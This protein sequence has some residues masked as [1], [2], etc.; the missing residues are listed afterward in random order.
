MVWGV[1]EA[2]A[3]APDFLAVACA[4]GLRALTLAS[5][6]SPCWSSRNRAKNGVE[7]A[8]SEGGVAG[9]FFFLPFICLSFREAVESVRERTAASSITNVTSGQHFFATRRDRR[10]G[11]RLEG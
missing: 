6:S 4:R 9:P 11:G 2:F 7:A 1:A 3:V 8:A 5:A 10:D